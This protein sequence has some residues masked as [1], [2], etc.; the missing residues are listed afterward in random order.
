MD[1]SVV[2][3]TYNEREN[4]KEIIE[5][6]L[7]VADVEVVVVDDKSPDGTANL[8]R[9][10]SHTYNILVLEREGKLGLSSAILDGINA[11]SNPIVGVIDADLSH[12]P[13]IIP[14]LISAV[15]DG[16]DMALGSRKTKGGGVD[17]WP[18]W[19]R[20]TSW[21]AALLARPLTNVKDPM[22]GFFFINK[23]AIEGVKLD[24]IGF[25]LG[26]EI[27]V[28]GRMKN[29]VEVP[30]IFKDRKLGKSKLTGS[31]FKNYIKHLVR[32]YRYKMTI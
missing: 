9:E 8:A 6:I 13:R 28:K 20:A 11:S 29:I 32:L 14:Q 30:Y 3:P 22:S 2:I 23:N 5:S 31:E 18:A 27:I 25:K 1:A 12:D 15:R 17:G 10:L 19:R 21:G 7:S 4:L 26:L 24:T 16:A